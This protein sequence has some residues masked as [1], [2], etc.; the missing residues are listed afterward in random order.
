[1]G[2]RDLASWGLAALAL[3]WTAAASQN[4]S[5]SLYSA[6]FGLEDDRPDS[7]P[8]CF[9]CLLPA[10][11]CQQFATCDKY[12]G[13]CAC[14]SGFG[15]EDC[16]E[17]VCG[18]L[19]DGKERLPRS[20]RYCDC[21]DGWEGINCNVCKHDAACD[22]LMPEGRGGVCYKQGDVIRENY[23]GCDVT[24]RKILDLL[25]EDKP[26]ITFSCNAE[27]QDCSFQCQCSSTR[28]RLSRL[29]VR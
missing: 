28:P 2:R 22:A 16:S 3:S 19:A 20:E 1:M 26:Q 29:T 18:S 10:F 24:N 13:K 6:Q 12:N 14:P 5:S 7:C 25:K 4:Y 17:P 9:N 27:R 23:Q 21:R 15:K 8:P 11:Q